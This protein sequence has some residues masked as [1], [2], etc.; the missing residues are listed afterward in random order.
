MIRL[1]QGSLPATSSVCSVPAYAGKSIGTGIVHLGVGNFHRGHQLACLDRVLEAGD[2]RWGVIGASLRSPDVRD[3]LHPQ[4]YLYTLTESDGRGDRTRLIAALRGMI[5]APQS[6]DRLI[7]ALAD[8]SVHLVTLTVTEKGY[9]D[10]PGSA[11]DFIA[12]ALARRRELG[13]DPFTSISCDNRAGNGG[14]LKAAVLAAG[15]RSGSAR[16]APW[17]AANAAFPNAMVDRIVPA[18]TQH[19]LARITGSIGI[20]DAAPIITEPYFQWVIEDDFCANRP[21]LENFGVN[22]VADVA[23]WEMAKLRLLNGAH[24]ALAYLAGLAGIAH[25]HTAVA[26]ADIR[27]MIDRLWNES[28]V[29]LPPVPGLDLM[30]YRARLFQRFANPTLNHRT[31]QIA[32]DGSQKLPPRLIAPMLWHRERGLRAP[33]LTLVIAAWMRWQ[34][35]CDDNG[36]RYVVDDPLAEKTSALL[37]GLNEPAD[38][39]AALLT[40]DEVFPTALSHDAE[41]RA[42]LTT[43]LD[44]L[45]QHGARAAMQP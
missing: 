15:E 12:R 41:F 31:S 36:N 27:A 43:A 21:A 18:N 8:P 19:D 9:G 22:L 38:M 3:A 20:A 14:V 13:I 42:D 26:D 45:V 2:R 35:G 7:D 10:G 28:A 5:V 11:A 33:T 4:D 6:P 40:L 25:V 32:I 44:R 16:L 29:T 37:K 30:A 23:P 1:S 39:V 34:L 17:I 24:S